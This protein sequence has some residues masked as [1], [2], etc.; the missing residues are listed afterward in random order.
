MRKKAA[1]LN[2]QADAYNREANRIKPDEDAPEE[3]PLAKHKMKY[4]GDSLSLNRKEFN[5]FII[6]HEKHLT[7][8]AEKLR[9][10]MTSLIVFVHKAEK[11]LRDDI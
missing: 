9:S 11:R 7:V 5:K 8:T 2:K 10:E 6:D 3:A 4:I 1:A